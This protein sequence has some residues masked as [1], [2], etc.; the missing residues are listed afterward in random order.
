MK[1]EL[2]IIRFLV[3]AIILVAFLIFLKS[4]I[5]N[6]APNQEENKIKM[7]QNQE[8]QLELLKGS[9]IYFIGK[10]ELDY[11]DIVNYEYDEL[12]K[13]NFDLYKQPSSYTISMKNESLIVNEIYPVIESSHQDKDFTLR[14]DLKI[15]ELKIVG[16]IRDENNWEGSLEYIGAGEQL[17]SKCAVKATR[18]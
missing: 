11:R 15:V 12:G 3:I 4:C 17:I 9:D 6:K 16:Q 7:Q 1:K 10:W 13:P 14:V 5:L 18:N 8:D 2:K